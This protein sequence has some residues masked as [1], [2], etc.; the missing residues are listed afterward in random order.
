MTDQQTD[1]HEHDDDGTSR[2]LAAKRI[3]ENRAPRV[4][5]D[6]LTYAPAAPRYSAVD[7]AEAPDLVLGPLVLNG[8]DVRHFEARI[9]ARVRAQIAADIEAAEGA[10]WAEGRE[11]TALA[12]RRAARIARGDV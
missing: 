9:E 1:P 8:A 3:A 7:G 4:P 12:F 11:R 10:A 5:G 2:F 6:P